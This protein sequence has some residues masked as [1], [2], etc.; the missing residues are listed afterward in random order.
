MIPRAAS[1]IPRHRAARNPGH[2]RARGSDGIACWDAWPGGP[3]R[4]RVRGQEDPDVAIQLHTKEKAV[5]NTYTRRDGLTPYATH[6]NTAGS[7]CEMCEPDDERFESEHTHEMFVSRDGASSRT[8]DNLVAVF[9]DDV[10]EL[11]T[12]VVPEG[13]ASPESTEWCDDSDD[14]EA[15]QDE[16][17]IAEDA[18]SDA[19]MFVVWEDG[20][21]IQSIVEVPSGT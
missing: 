10:A 13:L 19:D 21:V 5:T 4:G 9:L 6:H 1:P 14:S 15:L 3:N 20:Y 18:L 8:A 16:A 2:A 12:Y 7:E 11:T 17:R